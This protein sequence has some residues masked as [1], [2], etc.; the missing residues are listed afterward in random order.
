MSTKSRFN[1]TYQDFSILPHGNDNASIRI[2]EQAAIEM[3]KLLTEMVDMIVESNDV[4]RSVM[5]YEIWMEDLNG[6]L[7]VGIG[8]SA[9]REELFHKLALHA[10]IDHDEI[11]LAWLNY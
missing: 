6:R 4:K 5:L 10:E 8:D 7:Q 11:Y 3:N 9:V 1:Y 2:A